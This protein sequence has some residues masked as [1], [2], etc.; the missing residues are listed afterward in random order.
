MRK[1][2]LEEND[3]LV[4]KKNIV[5]YDYDSDYDVELRKAKRKEDPMNKYLDQTKE[6]P[7]KAMCRYQSPYNRFNILAG[8]RWD[9]IVRGNGFEKRRFEALKLKQHRDKLAYLNNVS[10]L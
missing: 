5:N 1:K 3:K 9:G 10:D 2:V 8:Y 4:K 6:Q 7:E